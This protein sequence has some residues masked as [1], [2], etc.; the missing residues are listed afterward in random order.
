MA[1]AS[2]LRAFWLEAQQRPAEGGL[3]YAMLATMLCRGRAQALDKA[4]VSI[5]SPLP[6]VAP[7]DPRLY[8]VRVGRYDRAAAACASFAPDELALAT[9]RQ[10]FA[11]AGREGDSLNAD[12]AAARRAVLSGDLAERRKALLHVLERVDPLLFATS[13]ESLVN[14]QTAAEPHYWQEGQPVA[15]VDVGLYQ[16]ALAV[17]P[18]RFGLICDERSPEV[19]AACLSVGTCAPDRVSLTRSR[20]APDDRSAFDAL[21][22]NMEGA[23]RRRDASWFLP[24]YR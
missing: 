6:Y 15:A 17:L 21:L 16:A 10:L 11:R 22:D 9:E 19:L 4:G 5:R 13:M 1:R 23:V 12:W 14:V 18:C 7:E 3:S 2:D 8:A 20:L 24:L